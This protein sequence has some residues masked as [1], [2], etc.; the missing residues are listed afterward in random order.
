MAPGR[1]PAGT[2]AGVFALL[3]IGASARPDS[4]PQRLPCPP[5]HTTYTQVETRVQPIAAASP[6]DTLSGMTAQLSSVPASGVVLAAEERLSA[7][8][9][10]ETGH[11]PVRI[12][13]LS[14]F[15]ASHL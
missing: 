2:T 8:V 9:R 3:V 15:V 14:S 10:A 4:P 13:H 11:R 7:A 5:P 1:Y 12:I 6:P